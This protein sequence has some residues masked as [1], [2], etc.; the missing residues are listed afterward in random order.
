MALT[1]IPPAGLEDTGVG[2]GTVGS[3]SQIPIITVNAQGQVTAKGTAAL[4]L[5]SKVNKSGDS[6]SG[7]L[8]MTS[9]ANVVSSQGGICLLIWGNARQRQKHRLQDGG[10]PRP[11]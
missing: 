10:R 6:M 2:A 11:G 9:G 4:D 5:S 7:S 1:K 8:S 3:A